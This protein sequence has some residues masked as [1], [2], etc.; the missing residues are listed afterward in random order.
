MCQSELDFSFTPTFGSIVFSA[1]FSLSILNLY[2]PEF[3]LTLTSMTHPRFKFLWD[4]DG[5]KDA[6]Q[7]NP[8]DI[9]L[10][11]AKE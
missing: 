2:N 8:W 10:D 6:A 11:C 5:L 4:K 1:F 7:P 9:D 3:K